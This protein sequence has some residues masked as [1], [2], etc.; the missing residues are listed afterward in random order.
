MAITKAKLIS[1]LIL[2]L[3]Q[4]SI[5]DDSEIEESQVAIWIQYHLHSLQRQEITASVNAGQ[6]VPPLYVVT[7]VG[8]E[9]SEEDVEGIADAKQRFW[10]DLSN[11]V[12][13]LPDD[14]GIV[15]VEDYDGNLVLKTSIEQLGM[16]RDLK[17]S[18]PSLN[19]FLHYRIGKKVFIEGINTADANFNPFIV[20]YVPKQ[21]VLSMSDSDEVLVSNLILP[22]LIDLVV[23]RGKA[24]LLGSV[25]ADQESDGV[26]RTQPV[27]HSQIANPA[28][29]EAQTE[30]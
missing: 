23:A 27:Y 29:K 6:G 8:L 7:E 28:R 13:D 15:R 10:I 2:Q 3:T 20:H 30:E 9:M 12:L 25:P 17:F 26:H 18:K 16:V 11:D 1:D 19:N 21:D 5:S 24:E 22:T 4:S 14:K